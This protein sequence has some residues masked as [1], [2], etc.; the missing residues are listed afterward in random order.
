MSRPKGSKLSEAAKQK[1]SE[2]RIRFY[3]N[4]GKATNGMK[5]KHHTE[6]AK[7]R[8]RQVNIEHE[9]H[10]NFG[11]TSGPNNPAWKGGIPSWRTYKKNHPEM[12]RL[13]GI[14][15]RAKLLNI[16]VTFTTSTFREWY[17]S[18]PKVCVYCGREVSINSGHRMD[19]LSF[20]RK[21]NELGYVE[22]NLCIACNRCN[23]VKGNFFTFEQMK[24][25]AEKYFKGKETVTSV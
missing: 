17:F 9:N 23:T 7:E 24:E 13:N 8:M 20:D 6:E 11:D 1:M 16:P 10:K 3:A 15:K 4:G 18:T 5:G 2:S 25:I 12:E 22:G 14:Q 21:Y 19:S